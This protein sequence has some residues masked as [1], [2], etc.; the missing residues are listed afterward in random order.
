M[1]TEGTGAAETST[2]TGEQQTQ[3]QT[4]TPPVEGQQQQQ[5]QQ[6]ASPPQRPGTGQ[7]AGDD[8]RIAGLTADLQKE[9]RA[10]Q[11]FERQFQEHQTRLAERDRQIAA[12]TSTRT[13]STEEAEIAE[14]RKQFAKIFPKLAGLT[15]EQIDKML[16]A[17][18]S[19]EQIQQTT[20]HYWQSHGRNMTDRLLEE[21][22]TELGG[23]LSARQKNVLVAAYIQEAENNPEF[24]EKH[25]RGD[26]AQVKQFA[27][28]YV[29]DWFTAAQRKVTATEVNRNRPV[30]RSGDRS[31]TPAAGQKKIDFKNPKAVE[32]AMVASFTSHGGTFGD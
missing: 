2:G 7:T 11:Q 18:T 8:R 31:V 30:P 21:V 22:A 4:Q 15:D 5:T 12:L 32:D 28:D 16:T 25:E 14:V 13:P 26:I 17:S 10:R 19:A 9:R 3:Q 23:E 20:D 29:S 27:K 1:A 24:L 6:T